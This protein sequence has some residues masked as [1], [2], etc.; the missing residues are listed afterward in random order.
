MTV[1]KPSSFRQR[2]RERLVGFHLILIQGCTL[3]EPGGPWQPTSALG[4]LENL[5]IFIQTILDFST[6]S[7]VWAL[8]SFS[9]SAAL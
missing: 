5:S 2:R 8:F 1:F 6:G 7:E 4:R 9:L 3:A